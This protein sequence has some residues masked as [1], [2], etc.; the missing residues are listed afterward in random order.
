ML[1]I[2]RKNSLYPVFSMYED[3]VN[4]MTQD[5]MKQ[6][7]ACQC[8]MPLDIMENDQQFMIMADLPGM[9]KENV[10]I[11]FNKNQ[12]SIEAGYEKPVLQEGEKVHRQ[13]R[14]CGRYGR[15]VHLP[16]HIQSDAISAKMENG[17]LTIVVPKAEPKKNIQINID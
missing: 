7:D 6:S 4:K 2:V 10:K 3:F 15:N 17:V 13:E 9:A 16:E 12:L 1:G 11:Q 5:E 8:S 14:Y